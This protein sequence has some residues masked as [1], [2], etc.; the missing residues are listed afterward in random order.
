[1]D[2][3]STLARWQE[4]QITIKNLQAEERSLRDGLFRGTFKRP[5]EGVN[6]TTLPDG[7]EL[8]GTHK[9]NRNVVQDAVSAVPAPLR[10]KVFKTTHA[11]VL[12]A[13]RNLDKDEQKTV[14]KAL[15]ITPGLPTLE[16]KEAKPE[17]GAVT[18]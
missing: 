17:A 16:I 18:P 12:S 7:R 13:Y 5:T 1:M 4:L 3:L 6:K 9:L 10:K 8:K 11:L 14:D 15:T 2:Y